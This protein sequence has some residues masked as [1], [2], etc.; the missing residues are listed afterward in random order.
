MIFCSHFCSSLQPKLQK[1][2]IQTHKN[3]FLY[4]F[5]TMIFSPISPSFKPL[6]S[7]S[8]WIVTA[9]RRGLRQS[10]MNEQSKCCMCSNE[11]GMSEE[12]EAS[13]DVPSQRIFS[14]PDQP[15][16]QARHS[17]RN[18]RGRTHTFNPNDIHKAHWAVCKTRARTQ[19]LNE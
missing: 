18:T 12:R 5:H 9:S 19:F 11:W 10:P 13:P 4:F 7:Q 6:N 3:L 15:P 14:R 2:E 8:S 17:Y 16:L 1:N